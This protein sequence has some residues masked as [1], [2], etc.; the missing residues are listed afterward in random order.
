MLY[1]ILKTIVSI[2][3]R[4]YYREVR[5]V[6]AEYLNVEG[7]CIVIAN[8][9]NTLMDAWM[10]GHINKRRVHFM[11]K[12]TFFSS[13]FK[14]KILSAL[15]MIPIN[16]KADGAVAGVN[17]RD[18]FEACY[19]LLEKGEILVVFPEGTSYLERKLREI[20]SGTARIALEV[21]RRNE[22]KLK[23]KIIPVGLNYISADS[24]RG[25]VMAHVG[26]PIEL[27]S[28]WKD[29]AE[30][31]GLAAKKLTERFRTEL[32]RVF[33][34]MDDE[35]K[36]RLIEQLSF[37]FNTRYS[38]NKEAVTGKIDFMKKAKDKLDEFSL[39]EPWKLAEIQEDTGVLINQLQ[40]YGVRPDFLDRPYRRSLYVRQFIQSFLFLLV[41]LPLFCVGYITNIVPYKG[42]GALVPR[43]T[44]EPEYHAP[45]VILLGIVLYPVNYLVMVFVF[46]WLTDVS[47]VFTLLLAVAMPF[48]GLFAHFFMRYWKHLFSK[49]RFNRFA[50]QRRLI[51]QDLKEQRE[52]L[53]TLIFKD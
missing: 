26:K 32:S 7:P 21:E 23:L 11:A 3:I 36:E 9:P 37:L 2:G 50:K 46:R 13:P 42:I 40:Y 5:I 38:V 24:F 4:L 44:K 39:T 15:G 52:A 33:V 14:R 31:A 19:E 18:S 8:H 17:N 25:R 53:N 27:D 35:V 41:T 48:V 20:K 43:L 45:L 34:T 51:F 22:G 49:Q 12:A 28:E 10:M 6:N 29:F 1:R 16:R 30:N 47:W